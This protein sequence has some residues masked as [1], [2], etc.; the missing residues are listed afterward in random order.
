[1]QSPSTVY[2]IPAPVPIV[3]VVDPPDAEA[4]AWRR[5]V[6]QGMSRPAPVPPLFVAINEAITEA[7]IAGRGQLVDR[8]LELKL[9]VAHEYHS[10][11]A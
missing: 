6:E 4:V 9:T 7:Y 10:R 3:T 5:D 11:R 2:S 1:M 8:L